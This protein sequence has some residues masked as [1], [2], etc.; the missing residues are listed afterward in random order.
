M[1]SRGNRR[2][3]IYMDN[4]DS[5]CFLQVL[6]RVVAR[7]RWRCH[8]Y[9][10]MPNHFHS[11]IETPEPNLSYGLQLLNGRYAQW[12]NHRHGLTT[13]LFQGRFHSVLVE[14]DWH[15]LQ[16]ARYLVLNP[17]RAGLCEKPGDWPWSSYRA[18]VGDV[19]PPRFLTTDWLLARFGR[20]P[21]RARLAFERFVLDGLG[22][23]GVR[24]RTWLDQPK[25]YTP[26]K[27]SPSNRT[28]TAPGR[29]TTFR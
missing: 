9:C 19:S 21:A 27:R 26:G 16:L 12:F 13:H 24:P 6:D 3:P 1:T 23:S 5:Q 14:S 10:L 7:C 4:D 29:P 17:V 8:L 22:Q 11:V 28:S 2:Q 18:M 15:L 20:D 25:P